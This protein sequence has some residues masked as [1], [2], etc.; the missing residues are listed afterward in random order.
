MPLDI[1]LDPPTPPRLRLVIPGRALATLAGALGV[2]VA[3]AWLGWLGWPAVH[4][5]GVPA[6][7]GA[8]LTTAL[9]AVGLREIRGAVVLI[10]LLAAAALGTWWS[11]WGAII[12]LAVPLAVIGLAVRRPELAGLGLRRPMP[13]TTAPL[14][15]GAG[16]VLGAH[17]LFSAPRVFGYEVRV[18]PLDRYLVD[19]AYDAGANVLSGECVFR[20]VIFNYAHRR[21]SFGAAAATATGAALVRYLVDPALPRAVETIVGAMFY[22]TLLNVLSCA[23]FW[24][25]GS[26]LPGFLAGIGFFAGYRA[27]AGWW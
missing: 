11:A 19:L 16:L 2:T 23:L 25:S 12:Y 1:L 5:V 3:A 8:L 17:L 21:W 7:H 4:I 13:W 6:A 10:A 9:A 22:L 24:R 26:L 27:L 15:L 20:G 18:L 14:G